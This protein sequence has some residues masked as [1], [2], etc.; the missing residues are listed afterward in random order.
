MSFD[1][2]CLQS[3]HVMVTHF[4]VVLLTDLISYFL[5]AKITLII[6]IQYTK[7]YEVNKYFKQ[8]INNN[9]ESVHF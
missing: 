6:K 2:T 1:K 3:R 4:H 9:K 7:K 5:L 8:I